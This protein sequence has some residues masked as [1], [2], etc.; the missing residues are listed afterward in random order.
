MEWDAFPS[1]ASRPLSKVQFRCAPKAS[2]SGKFL[3]GYLLTCLTFKGRIWVRKAGAA[4]CF[5]TLLV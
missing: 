5:H 2:L 4:W 3:D 1:V